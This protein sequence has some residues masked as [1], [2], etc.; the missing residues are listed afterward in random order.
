MVAVADSK[1]EGTAVRSGAS[2]FQFRKSVVDAVHV[3]YRPSGY[4]PGVEHQVAVIEWCAAAC[5]FTGVLHEFSVGVIYQ[6]H[7]V[8]AFQR[9]AVTDFFSRRYA[10]RNG[11]FGGADERLA[12]RLPLVVLKVYGGDEAVAHTSVAGFSFYIYKPFIGLV[13]HAAF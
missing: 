5:F 13:K 3:V 9:S 7:D 11:R 8:G 6:K 10:A 1:E 2:F 4:V 12:E